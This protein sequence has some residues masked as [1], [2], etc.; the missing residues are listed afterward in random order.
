MNQYSSM[1]LFSFFDKA[2]NCIDDALINDVLNAIL[3]PIKSEKAHSFYSSI[4]VTMPS[5]AVD[6][7]S[8]LV[9][10]EPLYILNVV[11]DTWAMTSSPIKM[12]SVI[13]TGIEIYS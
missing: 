9:E 11:T 13:L 10:S 4:V 6:D 8:D 2:D 1:F 5:C 12:Q 3:C 7:M